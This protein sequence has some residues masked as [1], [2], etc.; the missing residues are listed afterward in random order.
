[1]ESLVGFIKK[2]KELLSHLEGDFP[3]DERESYME[4][5]NQLLEERGQ[6]LNKLPNLSEL[7]ESTKEEMVQLEKKMQSLLNAQQNMIKKDLHLL[8]LQKNKT[9]QYQ[10]PYGDFS[11]DGMYLDKKK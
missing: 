4:K 8:K 7:N 9:S 11:I 10:D 6:L 3:R 5:T 2:T 1:M